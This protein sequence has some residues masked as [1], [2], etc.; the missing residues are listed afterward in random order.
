VGQFGGIRLVPIL[1]SVSGFTVLTAAVAAV[2][3]WE[4]PD[5]EQFE[6]PCGDW[7][8]SG[9]AE[10]FA[11]DTQTEGALNV[12][13]VVSVLLAVGSVGT[14]WPCRNRGETLGDQ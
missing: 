8:A 3:C 14:R 11:P 7:L 9:R 1:V 6:L 4:L 13:L 5:D 10:L 12:L 2:W